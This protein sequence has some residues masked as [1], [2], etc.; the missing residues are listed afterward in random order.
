MLVVASRPLQASQALSLPV[1][2][3]SLPKT[4]GQSRQTAFTTTRVASAP[5]TR[6]S[7]PSGLITIAK[8]DRLEERPTDAVNPI[9]VDAVVAGCVS[10]LAIAITDDAEGGETPTLGVSRVAVGTLFMA[11]ENY[12]TLVGG[13]C[14]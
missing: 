14:V 9:E 4:V 1:S 11:I 12:P 5:S 2:A 6:P 13:D 3:S 8:T 7:R 10:S